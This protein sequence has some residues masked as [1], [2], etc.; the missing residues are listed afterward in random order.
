MPSGTSQR[1]YA[2]LDDLSIVSGDTDGQY[3]LVPHVIQS[4]FVLVA[5]AG[6]RAADPER[7]NCVHR[8]ETVGKRQLELPSCEGSIRRC[9]RQRTVVVV[10]VVRV[11]E[12]SPCT[13]RYV[14]AERPGRRG[15]ARQARSA[16]ACLGPN[17]TA[18]IENTNPL[19]LAVP[20]FAVLYLDGRIVP[21]RCRSLLDNRSLSRHAGL[22]GQSRQ[23]FKDRLH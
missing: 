15:A 21:A 12:V 11:G 4:D 17:Q 10:V 6:R 7:Y 3:L 22:R 1:I 2:N 13:L 20:L 23:G 18:L 14:R 16:L 19:R 8:I 9:G 5:D